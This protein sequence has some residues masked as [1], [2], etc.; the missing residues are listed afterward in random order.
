MKSVPVAALAACACLPLLAACQPQLHSAL[1]TGSPAYAVIGAEPG[2]GSGSYALQVGDV[3]T[4]NVFQ[5]PDLTVQ[6][7]PID[8]AGNL[9]LPLIGQVH[10]AG[11]TQAELSADVA[12]AYGQKY[13]RRP[14][15]AVIVNQTLSNTVSVEGEVVLPGVY[16]VQP[17]ATLLS[18]LAQ[19][20][21]PSQSAKLDEVLVFRQ[22]NGQRMGARF[23]VV[24][25]RSGR[26][27]DPQVLAGD[28]IV[29]GYSRVRGGYRDIL[30]AAPLLNVFAQ[31]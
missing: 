6:A 29:V 17:G 4:V 19:A 1:P 11:R 25:I 16:P 24:E 10:A 23:D 22:I 15:V 13:L 18:A 31:F 28:V 5:E 3:V 2:A 9:Y 8:N 7:V 20:R 26:A 21:S 27:P 14:Q 30:Q 12:Q